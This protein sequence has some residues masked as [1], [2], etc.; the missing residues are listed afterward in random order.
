LNDRQEDAAERKQPG[1]M[2]D[3]ALA[4]LLEQQNRT[5]IG[6]LSDGVTTKQD[7]NLDRYLGEPYGDEEEG[8]SN[9]MSMDVAEVVDWA[10]PDLLEPFI[11]GDR[12]VEYEP[13]KQADEQWVEQAADLANHTFYNDNR[14]VIILHDTIKTACIQRIGVIKTVWEDED[15]TTEEEMTGIPLASL[16]ALRQDQSI[17]IISQSSEPIDPSMMDPSVQQA[18][19][20]GQAYTIEIERTQRGGCNKLYSVPPEQFK[21]SARTDDIEKAEYVCH[22]TE[23]RRHELIEM[24]FDADVVAGLKETKSREIMRDDRRFQ[25]EM[26]TE[27]NPANAASDLLTLCEEYY[28]VDANGDG[29]AELLQVFR[30][31]K[32]ILQREEVEAHPFDSW[33]ADR[34]PNRLIGL[35]LADKAKQ[36]QRI[37]THLTRQMLDNVYLSNNPRIEV[38]SEASGENTIEDLLTYRIGGLIRTKGPGGQMRAI[39]V[40]DRS[41]TA[42][43]AIMYMDQVR[44]QQT[45]ITKNGQALNSETLDNKSAYQSRKEDRNEQVRKRLMTR[46][47]AETLL[48]PVFRKILKNIVRYQDFERTL[49][50]RGKWVTMDPRSWNADLAARVATGLG[51]ANREEQSAG[52]MQLLGIQ[53]EAMVLG[54]AQPKHLYRA[55]TKLVAALGISFPDEYFLNPDSPEGQQHAQQQG[56]KPDPKMLEVQ[57]KQ[58]AGMAALQAKTQLQQAEFQAKQRMVEFEAQSRERIEVTK[59][60]FEMRKAS[61]DRQAKL[62]FDQQKAAADREAKLTQINLGYQ[63]DMAQLDAEIAAGR[64]RLVAEME[65]GREELEMKMALAEKQAKSKANGGANGTSGT[66]GIGGGVRFGGQVG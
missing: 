37:K 39:E 1:E 42:L 4:L 24:D 7:E 46:M 29:R 23:V 52:M 58:Q 38:P 40:P 20:D 31:G 50:L 63:H 41:S 49:K 28:R 6:Y 35:G 36:T 61:A 65:L 2:T 32:T 51:H 62:A 30:V 43:N 44:E 64:E 3:E 57:G 16:E 56:Q 26:R 25:G 54:L 9:A 18:F 22:E 47:I 5:A 48:V 11:S 33:S 8:M 66:S 60:E 34:I 12:I 59:Q 55:A 17:K 21:I 10:L 14:G 13:A 19:Y 45:G 15:K 53:K 27:S